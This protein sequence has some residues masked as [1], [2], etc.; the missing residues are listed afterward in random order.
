LYLQT[1]DLF[2]R[3]KKTIVGVN[4]IST[5]ISRPFASFCTNDEAKTHFFVQPEC[6]EYEPLADFL[7]VDVVAAA[8]ALNNPGSERDSMAASEPS[9]ASAESVTI[10]DKSE[11]SNEQKKSL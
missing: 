1:F 3:I 5:Q 11:A 6:L 7:K 9:Q 4:D 10:G 8:A 2:G